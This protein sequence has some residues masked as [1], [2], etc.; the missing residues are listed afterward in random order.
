[1]DQLSEKIGQLK[2][3]AKE[4]KFYKTDISDKKYL[5]SK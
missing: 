1:M 3:Q 5:L 4:G 2:M